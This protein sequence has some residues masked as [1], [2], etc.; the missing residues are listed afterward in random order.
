[1]ED[2]VAQAVAAAIKTLGSETRCSFTATAL[3]TLL[4][5]AEAPVPSP[6]SVSALCTML[7]MPGTCTYVSIGG[8]SGHRLVCVNTGE[9]SY[10]LQSYRGCYSLRQWCYG[11]HGLDPE[12]GRVQI[13]VHL[14]GRPATAATRLTSYLGHA[15]VNPAA[16]SLCL[17]QFVTHNT[18]ELAVEGDLRCCV[19]PLRMAAAASSP[20]V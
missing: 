7:G 18:D 13:G 4:T 20:A 15:S 19:A 12:T 10:L 11:V 6:A 8:N 9:G 2:H 1:M 17:F 5:A 14:A 3:W 16:T